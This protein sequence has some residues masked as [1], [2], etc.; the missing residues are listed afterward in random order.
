MEDA[1][2][3]DV[4]TDA[5]VAASQTALRHPERA[6]IAFDLDAVSIA[7]AG[8]VADPPVDCDPFVIT[9]IAIAVLID[10]AFVGRCLI[11]ASLAP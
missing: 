3:A 7:L 2:E 10:D 8:D 1:A 5:E 9:N 4:E 6:A 11:V